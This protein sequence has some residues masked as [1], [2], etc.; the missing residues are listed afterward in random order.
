[1]IL[2]TLHSLCAHSQVV[3]TCT[4]NFTQ[5]GKGFVKSSILWISHLQVGEN[6]YW[7]LSDVE[8]LDKE[9]QINCLASS[10]DESTYDLRLG[11][12]KYSY[13]LGANKLYLIKT[14]NKVT[15]VTYEQPELQLFYPCAYMDSIS[16][17]IGG[18]VVCGD[19]EKGNF[20]GSV[21]LKVDATGSVLFPDGIRLDNL[22]ILHLS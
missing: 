22:P 15:K 1:M 20:R 11:H 6:Q 3:F 2:A 4:N 9:E 8:V 19:K 5:V 17:P 14:E 21:A 13:S 10:E 16:C 7:D 12:T 18:K